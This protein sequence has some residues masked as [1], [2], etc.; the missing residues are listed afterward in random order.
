MSDLDALLDGAPTNDELPFEIKAD[1]PT[2]RQHRDLLELQSP[3]KSQ[4]RRGVCSIFSTTGLMEHLYIAGG[5]EDPDF[6]EQYLQWSAKFEVGS[7]PNTS[8]SNAYYNLRAITQYGV[9]SEAAWP[10]EADQ[11]GVDEDEACDGED[12]QP[13]RCYTN[14]QAPEEALAAEKFQLPPGRWVN[15]RRA[16]IMDHI[17]VNGTGVVVGLEFFY[18]AWNHRRSELPRNLDSWDQGIVRYPNDEDKDISRE[19]PAGHSILIVGWDLD[20]EVARVDAEGNTMLDADGN[21]QMEQGFYLFKNSWGTEGF[22]ISHEAGAGYG[23]LSMEYVDELGRAYVS[24][25]PEVILDPTD[26]TDPTDPGELETFTSEVSID[27]PDNDDAGISQTLEV[28]SGDTTVGTVSVTV[29]VEHTWRGDLTV[30][31]RHGD[32]VEVL[33]ARS[34]GGQ[35][36]LELE[37]ETSAFEGMERGGDWTLEVVDSARLDSGSLTSWSISL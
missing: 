8:G 26:P 30:Q 11:W 18:Q 7:F 28:P 17:R 31:L 1:G 13:T 27:I 16:S 10:Y 22:G 14:G 21:P 3:V 4:G 34:G 12:D 25:I 19:S 29:S 20:K 36:D 2:P 33:H 5:M 24:D 32:V 23:W 37:L 9:P 15:S 35:D 6:S